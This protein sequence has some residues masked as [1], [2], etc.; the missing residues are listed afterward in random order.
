[1]S[2]SCQDI[3]EDLRLCIVESECLQAPDMTFHKC[4]KSKELDTQCKA[5]RTAYFECRRGWL[6]MTKRMMGNSPGHGRRTEAEE[7]DKVNK[8]IY[9]VNKQ[10]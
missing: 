2:S 9:Q 6:D 7:Q 8:G 3:R 1:M 4:I 5:L 10:K